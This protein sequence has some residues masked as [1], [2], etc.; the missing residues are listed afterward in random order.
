MQSMDVSIND[1]IFALDQNN[2]SIS[3]I[4]V[5]EGQLQYSLMFRNELRTLDDVKSLIVN[6]HGSPVLL[7]ELAAVAIQDQDPQ[8]MYL[9]QGKRAVCMALIKSSG[10]KI[11]TMREEVGAL[12][13]QLIG[14]YPDIYFET[15]QD[16]SFLLTYTIENLK[17]N[18]IQGALLAI[19]ILFL[20]IRNYRSPLLIALTLPVTLIISLFFFTCLTF[21]SISYHY[22]A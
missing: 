22:R 9:S 4:I 1:L 13:N 2:T 7:G 19:L 10:S 12:T 14:E 15:S 17:S 16:Q 6:V 18:L 8:G 5:R 3:G 20:F 21:Q 11:E